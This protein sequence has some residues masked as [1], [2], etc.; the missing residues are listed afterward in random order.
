MIYLI[1]WEVI[2]KMR[3]GYKSIMTKNGLAYNIIYHLRNMDPEKES[4]Y[5]VI[6]RVLDKLEYKELK[7]SDENS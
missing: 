2:H 7:K 3:I 5:D 4:A 6:D 1:R